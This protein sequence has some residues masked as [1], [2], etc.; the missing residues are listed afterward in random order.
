MKALILKNI[1]KNIEKT[2]ISEQPKIKNYFSK[3]NNNGID[4]EN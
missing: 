3:D 2:I 1:F 4:I